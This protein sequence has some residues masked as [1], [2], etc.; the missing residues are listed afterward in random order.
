MALLSAL[1]SIVKQP[2]FL[3]PVGFALGG[4]FA[5]LALRGIAWGEVRGQLAGTSL[6]ALAGAVG[7]VLFSSWL[8]ALRWRLTWASERVSVWRLWVVEMS[9]LGL[10][11]LAPVRLMD[12][13][14]VLTMLTLRDKHPAP[15]VV[16]TVVVT[17]VQDILFTVGFA[18]AALALEPEIARLA[19]PAIY[20]SGLLVVF[21]V[22][23]LNLGRL[24]RRFPLLGRIPGLLTYEETVGK[25]M[26]R[27]WNLA[28]TGA[29]TVIYSLMLGPAAW[30]LAQGM[31][32]EITLFQATI[33][34]LGAIFFATSLPGLPG[35]FGTFELAVQEILSL[36][37][38]PRELGFGFGLML[39]LLLWG[40]PTVFAVIVLPREGIGLMQGWRGMLHTSEHDE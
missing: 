36:W 20:L 37:D 1:F 3:V 22:L 18:A 39:H 2:R 27:R 8:R 19:G 34:T 32:V 7:V 11:N 40:P 24:A 4:F 30:L 35:A 13:P 26:R 23:L 9:A 10:N 29:L 25:A 14:A 21:F 17:R 38:V 28:A 31:G 16:A 6:L 5:Y 12:E 15:A 33:V